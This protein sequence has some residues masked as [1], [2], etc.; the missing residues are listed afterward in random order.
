MNTTA[1][2]ESNLKTSP[3]RQW[4][5]HPEKTKIHRPI[6]DF[7][8]WVGMLA[9]IYIFVMSMTGSFIV[10]RNQLE[11]NSGSHFISVVEWVVNL[12]D[13]LL[14]GMTGQTVNGIGGL[15]VT[16]LCITGLILWWPGIM[17]WKR[18][19]TLDWAGSSARVNWDLHNVVG[20]WFFLL[21]LLWG[22]SGTYFVFPNSF[23][24]VVDFW[25]PHGSTA[26]L[27]FGD[28]VL[29]WLS[30]LHFGRFNLF[31]E[32]LWGALGLVPAVLSF[33][34]AFMC[35]HRI[36]VRKGGPLMR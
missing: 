15:S 34:G 36:F 35:C 21:V 18:S 4:L 3:W 33:T 1:R 24:A 20:F 7:H 11:V 9:G 26:K 16:L 13:N 30:N 27:R 31:T 14:S 32:I 23:N 10:F 22:V 28:L 5:E 19:L 29:L 6:F 12:H 25:Q 8:L 17:H 2:S